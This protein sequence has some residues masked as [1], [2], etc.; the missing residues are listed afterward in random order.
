M[1]LR[2]A[3]VESLPRVTAVDVDAPTSVAWLDDQRRLDFREAAGLEML[4]SRVWDP[5]LGKHTGGEQLVVGAG[6]GRGRVEGAEPAPF[7]PEQF[8]QAGL[9][10]VEGR[11]DVEPAERDV[12][13]LQPL[14]DLARADEIRVDAECLPGGNRSRRWCRSRLCRERR[15]A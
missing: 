15:P 6:E 4:G 7:E 2:E 8:E 5:C 10:T 14:A 1:D 9:D 12:A 3:A 11:E 13:R